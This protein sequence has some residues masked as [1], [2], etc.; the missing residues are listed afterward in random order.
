MRSVL[1]FDLGDTLVEYCGLPLSWEAHYPQALA[2]LASVLQVRPS[3]K[4][5]A[6]A[7]AV[8]R[9]YNTRL[10]PRLTEVSFSQILSDLLVA[11]EV[12]NA[13]NDSVCA[14]AFFAVFRQR[15]RCFPEAA[16]ML[17]AARSRGQRIGVFT[18]VPYGMPRNLVLEDLSTAGLRE[19]VDVLLTSCDAGH[20]KPSPCT[21]QAVAAA[22]HSDCE[23]MV[24]IG[25]ERKDIEAAL[26][27]GCEAVLLDR[28]GGR[29]NWGQHRTISALTEL[30][31]LYPPG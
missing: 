26:A 15:L 5:M 20:R 29:P 12:S 9:K 4:M 21:L 17:R 16:S 31:D 14:E 19:L 2:R 3:P 24:Y 30:R 27:F 6:F 28:H 23:Q 8:L 13:G 1:T 11:W 22:F 7:Y 10:A 25:N 18:D